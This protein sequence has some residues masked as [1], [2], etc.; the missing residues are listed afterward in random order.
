MDILRSRIDSE[1]SRSLNATNNH[2]NSNTANATRDNNP[3]ST[4]AIIEESIVQKSSNAADISGKANTS[5]NNS[6]TASTFGVLK[7]NQSCNTCGGSFP[8]AT[9][10]RSHFRYC[11]VIIVCYFILIYNCI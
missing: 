9:S 4:D 1:R 3:N 7:T 10:Y 8:D 6:N 5:S 11:D 2:E